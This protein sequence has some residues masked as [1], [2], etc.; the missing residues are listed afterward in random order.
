MTLSTF[1]IIMWNC[2]HLTITQNATETVLLR[3]TLLYIV[4][5]SGWY[6]T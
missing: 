4:A 3:N 2:K 5:C 1:P 6:I